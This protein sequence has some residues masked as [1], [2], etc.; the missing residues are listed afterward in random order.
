LKVKLIS[1]IFANFKMVLV[2]FIWVT[3]LFSYIF[4]ITLIILIGYSIIP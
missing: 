2:K 4:Y 3:E 1:C